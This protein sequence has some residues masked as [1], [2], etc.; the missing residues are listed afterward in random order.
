MDH[1]YKDKIKKLL[2]LSLSD[3]KNEAAIAAKQAMALMNKHNLTEAEV[4]GQ[5]MMVKTIE[6]PY[7]RL[8]SWYISLHTWMSSLSGCLTVYCNGHADR[9]ATIEIAGRERDVENA[10]YLI[11]FLAR[12]LEQGVKHFK[13]NLSNNETDKAQLIKSYRIGFIHKI[14]SRMQ[15]SRN[16]FFTDHNNHNQ[17]IC[18]DH[19]TRAS[20]AR[21]YYCQLNSNA[22]LKTANTSSQYYLDGMRAGA[23]A[24]DKLEINN[25]VHGQN[26][27]LGIDHQ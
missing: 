5:K 11:V 12:A 21:H 17:L 14:Y 15:A 13:K 7:T 19:K 23:S 8:P 24:A 20:E 10:T 18:V 26:Q 4:Y 16:Q 2:E 25:A 1:K 27:I 9:K 22:R 3:N 6:T